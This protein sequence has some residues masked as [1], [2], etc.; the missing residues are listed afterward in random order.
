MREDL[1]RAGITV[2]ERGWLS[3]NN[4]LIRG[5]AGSGATLVDTGYW[6]HADQTVA[7]VRHALAGEPLLRV[8]NTHLH[9]D[10]CGG[11]AE[12]QRVFG[13]G[14]DVPAGEAEAA[15]AWDSQQLTYEATGQF[16]PRFRRT[17]VLSPGSVLIAGRWHWEVV[18]S[19]GHDPRSVALYQPDLE[20]LISADAL[21]ENGFG[22]VFPE[23]EGSSAFADV[24]QTLEAFS[25]LRVRWVIPGHGQPF[26]EMR[27]AVDRALRRL[28]GFEVDPAM[29]ALH[30]VKVLIKFRLLET[31]E[32][33]W[34]SLLAWLAGVRYFELVRRR[35]FPSSDSSG[36]LQAL[37]ESMIRRGALASVGNRIKNEP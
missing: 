25:C 10:H 23:L 37:V 20:V 27:S 5:A 35:Y 3:S 31:R 6:I 13:C 17:G 33:T 18:A 22:V 28:E 36:W 7:L 16:C 15:D 1:D 14:I 34:E 9:S 30:A 32:A 24:R 19:P 11:N 4:V 2:L 26:S 8:L 12:I 29:H 21:W